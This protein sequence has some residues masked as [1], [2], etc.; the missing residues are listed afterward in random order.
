MIIGKCVSNSAT[1]YTF[2]YP[3]DS[4]VAVSNNLIKEPLSAS[5]L[6]NSDDTEILLWQSENAN[7]V[8]SGYS[9]LGLQANFRSWLDSFNVASGEYGLRLDIDTTRDF[10][11]ND[12]TPTE[13]H[14]VYHLFLDTTDMYGDPYNFVSYFQ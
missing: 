14:V 5:L 10:S 11:N 3:F 1:T 4:L 7:I 8:L 9:R 12:A 13:Q 6:A 2:R